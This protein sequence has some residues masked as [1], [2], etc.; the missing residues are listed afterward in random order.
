MPEA[1]EFRLWTIREWGNVDKHSGTRLGK[2]PYYYK[3]SRDKTKILLIS[4][5]DRPGLLNATDYLQL[6]S[7][8]FK[9]LEVIVKSELRSAE[10]RIKLIPYHSIVS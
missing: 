5:V 4:A 2:R 10:Y 8:A 1:S 3:I 7:K 9:E 6:D